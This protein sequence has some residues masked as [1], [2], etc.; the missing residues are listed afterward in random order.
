MKY[1]YS[2][3]FLLLMPGFI[4]RPSTVQAQDEVLV[5]EWADENGDVI[6]NAL[7][8]A[9]ANDTDRPDNRVYMLKRGG[10]YWNEDRIQYEGFHLRIIGETAEEADPAEAFVCGPNF[11][12]DCGPA[13]IQRTRRADQSIDG[14]MIQ[15][16]GVTTGIS[17]APTPRIVTCS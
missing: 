10:F 13:I 6:I 1:S 15:N 14:V 2:L 3:L 12:E 8:D 16:S 9:I 4:V 11:D 17:L 5:V 7:R